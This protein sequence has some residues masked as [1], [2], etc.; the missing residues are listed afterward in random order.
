MADMGELSGTETKEHLG[1]MKE[2][3]LIL[4]ECEN[5]ERTLLVD[6]GILSTDIPPKSSGTIGDIGGSLYSTRRI[7]PMKSYVSCRNTSLP[8]R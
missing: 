8:K 5:D 7:L 3:D 4:R 2:R 6:I 1:L